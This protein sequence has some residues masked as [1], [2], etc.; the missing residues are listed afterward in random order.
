MVVTLPSM[1]KEISGRKLEIPNNKPDLW[2]YRFLPALREVSL[3]AAV[4]RWKVNHFPAST[5]SI[6]SAL[7]LLLT[8]L[9]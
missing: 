7:K 4:K 9:N 2:L 8:V 6:T 1:K 5:A 3:A